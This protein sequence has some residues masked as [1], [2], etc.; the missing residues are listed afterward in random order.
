MLKHVRVG[1]RVAV[2]DPH[3]LTAASFTPV[4]AF[5]HVER[6][7]T[8]G[9]LRLELES[10]FLVVSHDHVVFVRD[11]ADAGTRDAMASLVREG[12]YMLVRRAGAVKPE[13]VERV[14]A[15]RVTGVFAPQTEAGM[16]AVNGVAASCYTQASHDLAHWGLAPVRWLHRAFGLSRVGELPGDGE[17]P[18]YGALSALG[19][20]VPGWRRDGA[21]TLQ[22]RADAAWR[23]VVG[24]ATASADAVSG[25]VAGLAG[26]SAASWLAW[27]P[28]GK[29]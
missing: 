26:E 5:S 8:V 1:D 9:M 12:Q 16:L 18:V 10:T 13:R 27:W 15:V 24:A 25:A 17:H 2:V 7:V 4:M 21:D 22:D 14:V 28:T 19:R 3:E 23:A 6:N 29:M 20:A 11:A